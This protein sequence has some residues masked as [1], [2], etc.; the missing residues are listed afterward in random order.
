MKSDLSD[1]QIAGLLIGLGAI[2]FIIAMFVSEA[3]YAGYSISN[4]YIS[5]LGV[6]SSAWLFNSSIILLGLMI[7]IGSYFLYKG[8]HS[9][10][11]TALV[12]IAGVSAIGVGAFNE[13]FG[14]VHVLFSAAVFIFGSVAAIYYGAVWKTAARYPSIILGAVSLA[15]T[16]LLETNIY[17]GLGPGG[18]ERLIVYPTL[19]WAVLFSGSLL[20]S[21][22]LNRRVAHKNGNSK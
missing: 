19:L 6:G 16:I 20:S 11:F 10:I 13:N 4:N 21:A 1:L 2:Y 15:A 18:M 7:A 22:G 14:V 5:D 3:L 9:R 8:M 12:L 17:F